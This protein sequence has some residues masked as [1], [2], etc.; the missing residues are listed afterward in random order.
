MR[1]TL[2][3]LLPRI[4]RSAT[5]SIYRDFETLLKNTSD[6]EQFELAAMMLLA[7][8]PDQ[9]RGE[10]EKKAETLTSTIESSLGDNAVE[11]AR[12]IKMIASRL[13]PKSTIDPSAGSITAI[14][15]VVLFSQFMYHAKFLQE[16]NPAIAKP[17]I[18][19]NLNRILDPELKNPDPKSL[20]NILELCQFASIFDKVT[21]IQVAE[22]L[23]RVMPNAEDDY[24]KQRIATCL[25][26][27][28]H[29][30]DP[31]TINRSVQLFISEWSKFADMK[32]NKFLQ[33]D[34]NELTSMLDSVGLLLLAKFLNEK[35]AAL[36]D[37]GKFPFDMKLLEI[38]ASRWDAASATR[39]AESLIRNLE[40][41]PNFSDSVSACIGLKSFATRLDSTLAA[42]AVNSI[43]KH[44]GETVSQ[45]D[46]LVYAETITVLVPR[47]MPDALKRA[48]N[49]TVA[50]LKKSTDEDQVHA[51]SIILKALAPAQWETLRPEIVIRGLNAILA[52]NALEAE[53]KSES[54]TS[55]LLL[56]TDWRLLAECLA[57]PGCVG[58]TR[59][60]ILVR[61]EEVLIRPRPA[62][63]PE[64][65]ANALGAF[66]G[67]TWTTEASG[68]PK[69]L[70]DA[71]WQSQRQWKSPWQAIEFIAKHHPDFPLGRMPA[72][73]ERK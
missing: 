45:K 3:I 5:D 35:S 39:M 16:L 46:L 50:I 63:L 49:T 19:A 66:G 24:Q 12:S 11:K 25:C 27:L 59:D 14:N 73:S 4:S 34:I 61:L 18:M 72:K 65:M 7:S 15:K 62:A 58:W 56:T 64:P 8:K 30:F 69:A 53:E 10:I 38:T 60:A 31:S 32:Q 52:R 13:S 57:H 42:R 71:L 6:A 67:G 54:L 51:L 55:F 21:T 68:S 20:A 36:P 26:E 47:L 9:Y 17:V 28:G 43:L 29:K 33:S 40:L 70:N 37:D 48:E 1:D 41:D 2:I 44:V 23:I 22:Y